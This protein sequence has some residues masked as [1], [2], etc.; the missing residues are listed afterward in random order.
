MLSK[1]EA[2]SSQSEPGLWHVKV[3]RQSFQRLSALRTG[4][5]LLSRNIIFLLLVLIS[6]RG[7]VNTR[8]LVQPEGLGKLKKNLL[9]SSGIEPAT[10]RLVAYIIQIFTNV[11]GHAKQFISTGSPRLRTVFSFSK[12]EP[13]LFLP[14]SSSIVL[15]KL[16]GPRPRPTTYQKI[17]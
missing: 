5:A 10:F 13:L 7:W 4:H 1:H 9:A 8:V 2:G 15:T 17:W 14:S 3:P 12:P 6:F 16:S 11:F